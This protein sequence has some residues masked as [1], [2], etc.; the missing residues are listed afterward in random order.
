MKIINKQPIAT[1]K[2]CCHLSLP[3]TQGTFFIHLFL[4]VL[5]FWITGKG[6]RTYG[7]QDSFKW[8]LSWPLALLKLLRALLKPKNFAE[9]HFRLNN[10]GTV[11]DL[12]KT[13]AICL[14][15]KSI[16]TGQT[17]KYSLSKENT[18]LWRLHVTPKDRSPSG[19]F[20]GGH[21]GSLSDGKRWA[22]I[23]Y[24]LSALHSAS[25]PELHS[26]WSLVLCLVDCVLS[27]DPG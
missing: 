18:S 21:S 27:L 14:Q 1:L 22:M 25:V 19:S 17:R 7:N 12:K 9:N 13:L 3:P 8:A 5:D 16:P 24:L 15:K 11:E 26:H 4:K 10:I 20:G 23:L 2:F 6:V